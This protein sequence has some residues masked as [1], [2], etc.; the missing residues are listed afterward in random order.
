MLMT[1][2]INRPVTRLALGKI[3]LNVPLKKPNY[4]ELGMPPKTLD[5]KQKKN[6]MV[7]LKFGSFVEGPGGNFR[8]Q[9][10]KDWLLFVS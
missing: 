6:D 7:S 4:H 8:W 5:T 1:R 9:G 10:P 3:G 2:M